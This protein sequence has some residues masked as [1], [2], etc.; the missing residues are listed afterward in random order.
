MASIKFLNWSFILRWNYHYV[1]RV[2]GI[3]WQT[4]LRI[5][6]NCFANVALKEYYITE[7]NS[8]CTNFFNKNIDLFGKK[9]FLKK[10]MQ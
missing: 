9:F 5:K 8:C 6:P 2:S 3:H 4:W 7:S 10:W 1:T